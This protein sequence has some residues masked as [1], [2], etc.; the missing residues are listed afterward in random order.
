MRKPL[1]D[2]GAGPAFGADVAFAAA[3]AIGTD[4]VP[5]TGRALSWGTA[6]RSDGWFIIAIMLRPPASMA[7]RHSSPALDLERRVGCPENENIH[8]VYQS[9][10]KR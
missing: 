6:S 5:A 7:F 1:A 10:S 3:V 9:Y 2:L 8:L 4:V